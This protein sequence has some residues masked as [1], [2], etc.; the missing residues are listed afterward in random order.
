MSP[1]HGYGITATNAKELA[2]YDT[3]FLCIDGGPIKEHVLRVC[4]QHDVL[5]IDTGM[6]LYR[7][8]DRLAGILRHYYERAGAKRP[9]QGAQTESTWRAEPA[10]NMSE[11]S[12]SQN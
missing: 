7:I 2:S 1:A 11:T 6:G 9:P 8:D 4:E 10:G 5:C 3:V 12:N